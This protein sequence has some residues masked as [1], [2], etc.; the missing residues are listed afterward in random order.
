MH[1]LAM[2]FMTKSILL[3][4]LWIIYLWPLIRTR[5]CLI[6]VSS[7][8]YVLQWILV[9]S[10]F[11][12]L[13]WHGVLKI[14]SRI[15][16]WPVQAGV[17]RTINLWLASINLFLS[18]IWT[19]HKKNYWRSQIPDLY[20]PSLI[21]VHRKEPQCNCIPMLVTLTLRGYRHRLSNSTFICYL[22]LEFKVYF[23]EPRVQLISEL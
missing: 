3:F 20:W 12:P 13:V 6:T 22:F 18:E 14:N 10:I 5:H 15:I 1:W 2:M 21:L 16:R 23:L 19:I 9:W 17:S 11:S 8:N 7:K 4:G